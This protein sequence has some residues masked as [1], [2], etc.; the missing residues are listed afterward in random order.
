MT[1]GVPEEVGKVATSAVDALK[2]TP[3]VLALVIF[4]VLYMAG[5]FW[6]QARTAEVFDHSAQRWKDLVQ[7][8]MT[9]C[10]PAKPNP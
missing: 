10:V 1:P 2:S 5:S 3:V 9:Q 6:S 7:A 8:A 4:N